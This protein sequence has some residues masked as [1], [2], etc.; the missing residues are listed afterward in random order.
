[1]AEYYRDITSY[2]DRRPKRRSVVGT[3]IDIIMVGVTVCVAALFVATLLV[4]VLGPEVTGWLS[5]VGLIAPFVYAAQLLL[6]LYWV[7]RWRVAMM[8]PMAVLTLFALFH[9]SLFYKVALRRSY[10]EQEYERTAVKVMTYN[11]R[12]FI[13]DDGERYLDSIVANIKKFNPDI[14]CIQECGFNDMADSLLEPL[15]TLPHTV[16]RAQLS[17]MIYSRYPIL[18][19]GRVDTMKNFV[20]ADLAMRDDTVRVFSVHLHTTAISSDDSRYIERREFLDDVN[21]DEKLRSIV[22][23][24]ASNNRN[25][26]VQADT[27]AA[28]IAS[29]PYP[30]IVCGDFNDTPVS[31]T[32]RTV[33][34]NMKD[35]FRE[36]GRG[37]SYTYRGFFDLLRIDYVLCSEEFEPLSYGV[38]DSMRYSD[39]YPVFVR[40]RYNG[41]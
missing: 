20:W 1:M 30:V 35:A 31:Y 9:I 37:Y 34:D 14:L 40:L 19:A 27:L 29:S 10:G 36:V 24:L 25:R 26:A 13:G 38:V 22:S 39:H 41:R 18:R 4:P 21:G 6:T 17:P 7:V 2:D 12:S 8:I 32:Y 28:M 15:N 33:S 3:V 16:S 5:T 11:L 23:R